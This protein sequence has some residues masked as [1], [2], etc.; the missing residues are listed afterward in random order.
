MP[1]PN[2]PLKPRHRADEVVGKCRPRSFAAKALAE[3]PRLGIGR[4]ARRPGPF[5]ENRFLDGHYPVE[6][7]HQTAIGYARHISSV[8]EEGLSCLTQPR[9][10]DLDQRGDL[11]EGPP[12]AGTDDVAGLGEHNHAQYRRVDTGD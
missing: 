11:D 9:L 1:V 12:A 10:I 7:G 3:R 5:C 6:V 2:P 8:D 4:A